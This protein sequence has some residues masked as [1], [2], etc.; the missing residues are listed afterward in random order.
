MLEAFI[1][2]ILALKSSPEGE[3]FEGGAIDCC[4]KS[5]PLLDLPPQGKEPSINLQSHPHDTPSDLVHTQP[6]LHQAQ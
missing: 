6:N 4:F 2:H 3:D 5:A 1:L